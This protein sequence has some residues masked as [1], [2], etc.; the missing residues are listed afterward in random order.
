MAFWAEQHA[1]DLR[2]AERR[3]AAD[4]WLLLEAAEGQAARLAAQLAA[5]VEAEIEGQ[6][7]ACRLQGQLCDHIM[8][9]QV[10][11]LGDCVRG[12]AY[13]EQLFRPGP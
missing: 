8:V 12:M 4:A 2:H 7:Q 13:G 5:A 9:L 3:H 11:A 6:A 1:V 10:R